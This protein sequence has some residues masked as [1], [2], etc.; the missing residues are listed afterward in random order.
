MDE[1]IYGEEGRRAWER[2]DCYRSGIDEDGEDVYIL[3]RGATHPDDRA[4]A[5]DWAWFSAM[6]AKSM[7]EIRVHPIMDGIRDEPRRCAIYCRTATGGIDEI[8]AQAA[9]A[10]GAIEA[11]GDVVVHTY[12]DVNL[13]GYRSTGFGLSRLLND[14]KPFQIDLVVVTDIARL[15]RQIDVVEPIL[16]VIWHRGARVLS[17]DSLEPVV[18][19]PEPETEPAKRTIMKLKKNTRN[20]LLKRLRA[21]QDDMEGGLPMS[22][23][24]SDLL[25]ELI[26]EL[27]PDRAPK[28][29]Q[30]LFADVAVTFYVRT[31]GSGRRARPETERYPVGEKSLLVH[32]SGSASSVAVHNMGP[33]QVSA[34]WTSSTAV[35]S[36][37]DDVILTPGMNFVFRLHPGDLRHEP[38]SLRAVAP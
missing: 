17:L 11:R 34:C 7:H 22:G 10:R 3:I 15:G 21:I 31:H 37:R 36:P 27:T 13:A 16:S 23:H 12:Q 33:A 8:Q 19:E 1:R 38:V 26:D 4:R 6:M 20:K 25:D 14:L 35:P 2:G 24:Q 29:P 32:P 18:S 28:D 5:E 30:P 9:R